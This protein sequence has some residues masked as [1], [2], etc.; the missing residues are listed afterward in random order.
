MRFLVRTL[1]TA[2]ALALAAAVVDGIDVGGAGPVRNVLTLIG[3]ALVF[4]LVNAT[5]K[6]LVRKASGCIYWVTLGVAALVVNGLL[7][8]LTSWLAT[9]LGL[10]FSVDGFWPAFWGALLVAVVSWIIGLALPDRKHRE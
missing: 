1:V 2:A 8:L 6:P 10:P 3:V 4:G 9:R 7:F 5:I